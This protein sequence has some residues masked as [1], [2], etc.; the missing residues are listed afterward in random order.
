MMASPALTALTN[1]F[2]LTVTTASLVDDQ[3]TSL[4][5]AL[6]GK[7]VATKLSLPPTLN[8]NSL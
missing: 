8:S 6:V 5:V 7:T 1:P 2:S 3:I 4:L